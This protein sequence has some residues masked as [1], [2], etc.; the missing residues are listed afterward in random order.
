MV[1]SPQFFRSPV[2]PQRKVLQPAAKLLGGTPSGGAL[3]PFL[4]LLHFNE[5]IPKLLEAA[6]E[7]I[8]PTGGVARKYLLC[9]GDIVFVMAHVH[10]PTLQLAA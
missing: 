1:V 9:S 6:S 3:S 8:G 10:I 7:R 4:W 5:L 2:Y